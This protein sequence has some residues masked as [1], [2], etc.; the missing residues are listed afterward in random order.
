MRLSP[1]AGCRRGVEGQYIASDPK[2]RAIMV[3]AIEKR[4][5]VYVTNR[6]TAG[7]L[8]IAS[9]LGA[10]RSDTLTYDTV[11]ID[12]GF[13]NPIFAALET[14]YPEMDTANDVTSPATSSAP[15]SVRIP[16]F[17]SLSLSGWRLQTN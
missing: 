6:D 13:Q 5:L 16:I 10:H 11:G 4:K 3:S 7:N 2:G 17:P 8:T 9:P 14:T 12:N 15:T 1:G